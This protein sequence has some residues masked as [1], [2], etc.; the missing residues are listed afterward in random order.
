M[1]LDSVHSGAGHGY[2]DKDRRENGKHTPRAVEA[3]NLGFEPNTSAY[4]FFIP[5]N[6]I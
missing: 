3:I 4:C 1:S 2:L 6:T 5:E